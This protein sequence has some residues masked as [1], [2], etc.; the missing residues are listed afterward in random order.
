MS[1]T[2]VY[3]RMQAELLTGFLGQEMTPAAQRM[4]YAFRAM[5]RVMQRAGVSMR[6]LVPVISDTPVYERLA[7]E[8]GH[9]L[10]YYAGLRFSGS[11]P[12]Q[13]RLL[14]VSIVDV[15]LHPS[16]TVE[17]VEPRP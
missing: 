2:P 14:D 5:S 9:L 11:P 3:D 6:Q 8:R 4:I 12:N 10:Q 7:T 15:P 16:W 1:D 13:V 17:V